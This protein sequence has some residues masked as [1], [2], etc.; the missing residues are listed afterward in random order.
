MPLWSYALEPD[1]SRRARRI[2][3]RLLDTSRACSIAYVHLTLLCAYRL[4]DADPLTSTLGFILYRVT[5]IVDFKE[6]YLLSLRFLQCYCVL[7]T[8][9]QFFLVKKAHIAKVF[10]GRLIGFVF[11][12]PIHSTR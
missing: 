2:N 9:L 6:N 4:R 10:L 7:R 3:R 11:P 12:D 5:F 8:F 1:G